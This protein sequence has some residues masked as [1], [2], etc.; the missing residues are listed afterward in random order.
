MRR[1]PI[2]AVLHADDPPSDSLMAPVAARAE[3]RYCDKAG[4]AGA[5]DGADVLFVYDFLTDAVPGAWH[6][7]GSLQWLHIAAA[8]VDPVMFPEMRESEVVV[9]NSRGV[10][11]GAIAEYVLAQILS[12]AKDLPGSLRLQQAHTWK[13]RE[14]ER[15]AGSRALVVGT[16]PIGRAIARLLSAVGMIVRGSGRRARTADPDFDIVTAPAELPRQLGE[17][18]YVIAVAPLTEETR[19]M[20]RDSTFAAMKPGSR[21]INVGR[22]ELVRTDDL[23]AA[24]RSGTVAGAALDVFD[25]EPLAADHPLWSMPNVSVTPHNS[26]DFAGW[27]DALISVFAENFDRWFEGLPLENVVDKHLGYVPSR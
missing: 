12:F 10:F 8:G 16:G 15:I 6:A 11:D 9:T 25:T 3:V 13:H 26:G 20:F 22:G 19:H 4:L 7:A 17:A 2:V 27:R 23:V 14:S 1:K 21:F 24:L 5:L 18:D